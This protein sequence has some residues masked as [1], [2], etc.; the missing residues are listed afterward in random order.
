MFE[1]DR[2]GLPDSLKATICLDLVRL[3]CR[4]VTLEA[5]HMVVLAL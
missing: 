4:G 3:L 5:L 1:P 2:I